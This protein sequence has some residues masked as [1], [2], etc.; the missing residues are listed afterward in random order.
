MLEWLK[1]AWAKWK[2]RISVVGG[3]LVIATA[4]GTCSVD[5]QT[6]SE[7]EV[8]SDAA[9]V[10]ETT[11]TTTIEETTVS[12]EEGTVDVASTTEPTTVTK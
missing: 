9:L 6:V 2:V 5:P 8:E 3:V 10:V 12:T 7:V 4:Y 1:T 11:V